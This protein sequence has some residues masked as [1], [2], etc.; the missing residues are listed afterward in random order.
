MMVHPACMA[1]ACDGSSRCRVA[2]FS[3]ARAATR[4]TERA[5]ECQRVRNHLR[6]EPILHYCIEAECPSRTLFSA[7][8]DASRPKEKDQRKCSGWLTAATRH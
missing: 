7:S 1:S 5:F 3:T 2:Q 6:Q 4:V 8:A